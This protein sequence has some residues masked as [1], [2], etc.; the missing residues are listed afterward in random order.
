MVVKI[1]HMKSFLHEIK[2]PEKRLDAITSNRYI[3]A[4][5]YIFEMC[6]KKSDGISVQTKKNKSLNHSLWTKKAGRCSAVNIQLISGIMQC[7]HIFQSTKIIK[8]T[9][10]TC[11]SDISNKQ[12]SSWIVKSVYFILKTYSYTR[13]VIMST[14]EKISLLRLKILVF[15]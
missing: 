3:P 11:F 7:H 2:L 6:T 5:K 10:I 9:Y 14:I 1:P 4:L 12:I 15:V 13:V 8:R